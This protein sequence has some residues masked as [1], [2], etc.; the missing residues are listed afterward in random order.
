MTMYAYF[1]AN[2][3]CIGVNDA[4][5]PTGSYD[6]VSVIEEYRGPNEVYWNGAGAGTRI[7]WDIS[8]WPDYLETGDTYAVNAPFQS[9]VRVN[10]AGAY[11]SYN[12]PTTSEAKFVI[13]LIGRA[14]ASKVIQVVDLAT[15]K[16]AREVELSAIF[17]AH[18]ALGCTS[19]L[20]WVDCDDKAKTRTTSRFME[21]EFFGLSTSVDT[22]W[23]MYDQTTQ[24]HTYAQ[25]IDLC[26]AITDGFQAY[27]ANKQS[28]SAD[29]EAAT[30][31]ATL[32]AIDIEMGWPT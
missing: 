14:R 29:I 19:P 12:I 10:G 6:E 22:I 13:E 26:T 24:T 16:A 27:F 20:G 18:L 5:W 11:G 3:A 1:D 31:F 4:V 15:R 9:S 30:D 17:A 32:E 28:L 23:T 21:Y 7:D 2:R 8:D 25:F